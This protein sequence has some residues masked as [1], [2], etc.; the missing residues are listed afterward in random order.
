VRRRAHRGR[1]PGGLGAART[2]PWSA[3]GAGGTPGGGRSAKRA[4]AFV[5][6]PSGGS[7]YGC[8]S[9]LHV[10]TYSAHK[11]LFLINLVSIEYHV[12]AHLMRPAR[13]KPPPR[14]SCEWWMHHWGLSR[15]QSLQDK[16][17]TLGNRWPG[18]QSLVRETR[19]T[20]K[21]L[22]C[23]PCAWRDSADDWPFSRR[24]ARPAPGWSCPSTIPYGGVLNLASSNPL[25]GKVPAT[26]FNGPSCG[27]CP[28]GH[29]EG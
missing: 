22:A 20:R 23:T 8:T 6:P 9:L 13:P 17:L 11:S 4:T 12:C 2:L 25:P 14:R 28:T 7:I 16:R 24:G 18:R 3:I 19:L 1:S 29:A 27:F 5:L 21:P 26:P 15:E 10:G